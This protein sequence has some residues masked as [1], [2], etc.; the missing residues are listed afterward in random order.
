MPPSF[1]FTVFICA[2][3]MH[4]AV[5]ACEPHNKT[6]DV[7]TERTC[8]MHLMYVMC[9]IHSVCTYV[10]NFLHVILP[11]ATQ[12]KE[13]GLGWQIQKNHE[14]R[15]DRNEDLERSPE[16]ACAEHE[17]S[18][19]KHALVC[20]FTG[21]PHAVSP[22]LKPAVL[23]LGSAASMISLLCSDCSGRKSPNLDAIPAHRPRT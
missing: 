7:C 14:S 18:I 9:S 11:G 1:R 23:Q 22:W 16:E 20:A 2:C 10:V 21:H 13:L 12:L 3:E 6:T 5:C 4:E 17:G 8:V 15:K 19:C